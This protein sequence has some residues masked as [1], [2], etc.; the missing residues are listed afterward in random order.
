M[1][2]MWILLL[3]SSGMQ[4]NEEKQQQQYPQYYFLQYIKKLQWIYIGEILIQRC[5]FIIQPLLSHGIVGH[6]AVNTAVIIDDNIQQQ[7]QDQSYGNNN[8]SLYQRDVMIQ[9]MC[10]EC[11]C[12]IQQQQNII[13]HKEIYEQMQLLLIINN[14]TNTSRDENHTSKQKLLPVLP[15]YDTK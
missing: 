15:G 1:I 6:T 7:Q 2:R 10:I 5:I 12:A 11:I 3:P 4:P 9:T 13:R 14:A 8:L